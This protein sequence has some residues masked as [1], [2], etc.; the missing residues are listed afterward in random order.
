MAQLFQNWLSYLAIRTVKRWATRTKVATVEYEHIVNH[1][2]DWLPAAAPLNIKK[3]LLRK[4][5][6]LATKFKLDT[7]G[8][9]GAHCRVE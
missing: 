5:T 3:Y 2:P 4:V 1:E 6:L 7:L 9:P 8:P